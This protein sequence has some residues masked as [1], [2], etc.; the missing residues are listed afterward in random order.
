MALFVNLSRLAGGVLLACSTAMS[1]NALTLDV[2]ASGTNGYD[3]MGQFEIPER[4]L[5]AGGLPA[6]SGTILPITNP[7]FFE[8]RALRTYFWGNE[9]WEGTGLA[10]N[11]FE[12][13]STSDR[14]ILDDGNRTLIL[15]VG[16]RFSG[17]SNSVTG[18]VSASRLSSS[19]PGVVT[20]ASGTVSTIP[21]PSSLAGLA[22]G[23]ALLFGLRSRSRA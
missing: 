19:D 16:P 22:L 10:D 15:D 21:V 23:I 20:I 9:N 13:G 8:A 5:P 12:V 4:F 2:L 14:I 11:R 17:R 3:Y 7:I 6:A 1:A 18:S